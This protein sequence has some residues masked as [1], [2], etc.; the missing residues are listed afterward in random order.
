MHPPKSELYSKIYKQGYPWSNYFFTA[1]LEQ[2]LVILVP[3]DHY[4]LGG[5]LPLL[6]PLLLLCIL[7]LSC[8]LLH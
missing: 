1:S 4:V 3:S 6:G 8:I 5:L 2:T 7:L